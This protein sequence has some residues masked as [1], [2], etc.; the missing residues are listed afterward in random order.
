M[1]HKT[2]ADDRSTGAE[3]QDGAAIAWN[4]VADTLGERGGR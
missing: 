1:V 4:D 2:K 3:N